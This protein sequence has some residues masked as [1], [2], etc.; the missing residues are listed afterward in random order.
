MILAIINF[1]AGLGLC[2]LFIG[3]VLTAPRVTTTTEKLTTM[4]IT[5]PT[6]KSTLSPLWQNLCED[7]CGCEWVP[8][9]IDAKIQ[10]FK[11][12]GRYQ[13]EQA[14]RACEEL[15][16]E[17]PLPENQIQ[18]D[19]MLKAF[20]HIT[21]NGLIVIGL[22]DKEQ[23]GKWV[24]SNGEKVTYFN[25]DENEPNNALDGENY[26][27]FRI[28]SSIGGHEGKWND[29]GDLTSYFPVIC[30]RKR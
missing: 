7:V 4:Q 14:E 19:D 13:L 12:A 22:N 9:S 27:I 6:E 29:H 11:H 2:C 1:G 21:P 23:E 25:W 16:A 8:F 5:K 26:A 30:Q 20:K 10:C 15:G 18:N 3:N 24:K 28:Y 17:L